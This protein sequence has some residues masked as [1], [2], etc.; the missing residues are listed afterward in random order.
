MNMVLDEKLTYVFVSP[1]FL[2]YHVMWIIPLA[3]KT[4]RVRATFML[5]K[6]PGRV[7]LNSLYVF[8]E[9]VLHS[10]S[11]TLRAETLFVAPQTEKLC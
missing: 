11:L 4:I 7:H 2:F 8:V 3:P 5:E 9:R 10:H 6:I 1:Y